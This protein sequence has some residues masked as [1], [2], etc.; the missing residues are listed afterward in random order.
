VIYIRNCKTESN[1]DKSFQTVWNDAVSQVERIKG[2][3]LSISDRYDIVLSECPPPQGQFSPGLYSLDSL[4]FRELCSLSGEV[5]VVYPNYVG[6]V[7]GKRKYQKSESVELALKILDKLKNNV[8]VDMQS[9][10]ISHD[11]SEALIFL[12]RLFVINNM[13]KEELSEWAGFFSEK[14][15]GLY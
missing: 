10:R 1:S 7:H 9:K 13:F 15:K 6:H 4:L 3:L 12:C 8:K 5:R 11:E 2:V 14:E